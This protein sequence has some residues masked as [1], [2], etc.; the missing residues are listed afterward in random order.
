MEYQQLI[1]LHEVVRSGS[2]S[3]T[4]EK[5][6]ISRQTISAALS[7]LEEELGYPLL[8]RTKNGVELTRDGNVFYSRIDNLFQTGDQ[9]MEDMK[10]YSSTYRIPLSVGM[11]PMLE[12]PVYK[13][14]DEWASDHPEVQVKVE[15]VTG[16]IAT[17]RLIDGTLDVVITLMPNYPSS[18]FSSELIAEYELFLVA[19][20]DHDLAKKEYVTEKDL[21]GYTMLCTT[22]GYGEMEYTG[23]QYMPY[24][25]STNN[26]LFTEDQTLFFSW[27][28][29]NRG[30]ALAHK[31]SITAH[32]DDLC[33]IPFKEDFTLPIFMRMSNQITKKREYDELR[34]DLRKSL[35]RK[36]KEK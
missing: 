27:L 18:G 16:K 24:S 15:E 30:I 17:Q 36:L 20:K 5:L 31:N 10:N 29:H 1:Y 8:I 11:T 19:H 4:A 3:G 14:L 35:S 13:A 12:Y 9:L 7:R 25:P 6:F 28:L 22:L 34:R 33:L 32:I 26:Y 21:D 23:T 2:I